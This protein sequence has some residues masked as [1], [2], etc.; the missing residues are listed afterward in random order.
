MRFAPTLAQ[1][2]LV[3]SLTGQSLQEI[4][5]N[6]NSSQPNP[7]IWR[8]Q[9]WHHLPRAMAPKPGQSLRQS[10]GGIARPSHGDRGTHATLTYESCHM[11]V[12]QEVVQWAQLVILATHSM[13]GDI[14]DEHVLLPVPGDR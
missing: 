4:Q 9:V 6:T 5:P 13:E 3:H 1:A 14:R 2:V 10:A 11:H 7:S 12:R 8:R